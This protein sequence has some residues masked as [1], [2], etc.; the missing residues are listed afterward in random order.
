MAIVP[1][2]TIGLVDGVV[3]AP[4]TLI[5][6]QAAFAALGSNITSANNVRHKRSALIALV[7]R[8][9]ANL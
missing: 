1:P 8:I 3:F 5:V 2:D 7:G 6:V 4:G 9:V